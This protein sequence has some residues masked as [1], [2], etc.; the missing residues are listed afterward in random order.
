M[1]NWNMKVEIKMI[2]LMQKFKIWK[3]FKVF[4]V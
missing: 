3:V 1:K 2:E 4:D